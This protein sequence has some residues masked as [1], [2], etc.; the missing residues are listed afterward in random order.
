MSMVLMRISPSSAKVANILFM[1]A[2]P[3]E[4]VYNED[5]ENEILLDGDKMGKGKAYFSFGAL[6]VSPNHKLVGYATG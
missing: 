1:P 3:A 6:G 5:A 4:D 2:G